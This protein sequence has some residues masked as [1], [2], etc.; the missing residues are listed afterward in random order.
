M[1]VEALFLERKS[2]KNSEC[3]LGKLIYRGKEICKTLENPSKNNMPYVSC[4]LAGAYEVNK[5]DGKRY[6]DVWALKNVNSR[7]GILIHAGNIE[8]DTQ[9]CILVGDRYGKLNGEMAVLNSKATLRK[10]RSILPDNFILN[11]TNDTIMSEKSNFLVDDNGNSSSKR[12]WGSLLL[13]TGICLI[14]ILF[15]YSLFY[16]VADSQLLQQLIN[17]LFLS[18]SSLLGIGVLERFNLKK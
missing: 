14:L 17:V 12:L 8:S 11:I 7:T 2:A 18:G 16:K 9:G 15:G 3:T 1:T 6:Q 13:G 5:H 4:V 10:L